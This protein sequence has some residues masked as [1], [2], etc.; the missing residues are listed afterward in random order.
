MAHPQIP[1]GTRS[2]AQTSRDRFHPHPSFLSPL[3]LC[4]SRAKPLLPMSGLPLRHRLADGTK[5]GRGT[6]SPYFFLSFLPRFL[7]RACPVLPLLNNVSFSSIITFCFKLLLSIFSSFPFLFLF[8]SLCFLLVSLREFTETEGKPRRSKRGRET[9]E[10][11]G[12]N[13][14]IT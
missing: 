4:E 12:G 9:L 3:P 5:E 2:R 1:D 10:G 13:S 7:C 11:G 8:S 6:S 14:T